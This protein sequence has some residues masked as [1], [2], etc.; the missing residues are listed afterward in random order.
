MKPKSDTVVRLDFALAKIVV[1]GLPDRPG[2]AAALFH[3]LAEANLFAET[4][5]ENTGR[6]G[7][8]TLTLTLP[9]GK[10]LRAFDVLKRALSK[11]G[12]GQIMMHGP[13]AKLT[14]SGAEPGS[15]GS[16]SA[17]LFEALGEAGINIDMISTSEALTTVVLSPD[18]AERA[19]EVASRALEPQSAPD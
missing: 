17:R 13:I 15:Q 5:V 11:L 6:D 1:H 2:S 18:R 12:E 14:V 3:E 8:S 19:L 16:V 7:I 10:R 9:E 4:I